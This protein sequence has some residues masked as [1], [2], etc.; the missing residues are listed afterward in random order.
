VRAHRPVQVAPATFMKVSSR[1]SARPMH[2]GDHV[3]SAGNLRPRGQVAWCEWC[4]LV[5]HLAN[6]ENTLDR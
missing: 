4:V 5:A 2:A 1:T 6:W 3:S